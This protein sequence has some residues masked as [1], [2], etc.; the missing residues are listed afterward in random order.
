[1]STTAFPDFEHKIINLSE[2]NST[3][4][5]DVSIITFRAEMIT[6]MAP[7][8]YTL[9]LFVAEK[10]EFNGENRRDF[11]TCYLYD[12]NSTRNFIATWKQFS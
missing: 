12:S 11:K 2:A 8:K 4:A 5:V 6:V 1:M 3:H 7:E 10:I 9:E